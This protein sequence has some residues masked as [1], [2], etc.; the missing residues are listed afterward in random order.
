MSYE[1]PVDIGETSAMNLHKYIFYILQRKSIIFGKYWRKTKFSIS[2]K[3][4]WATSTIY[5]KAHFLTHIR[6]LI[7]SKFLHH[8]CLHKCLFQKWCNDNKPIKAK[9]NMW[10]LDITTNLQHKAPIVKDI[11]RRMIDEVQSLNKTLI[12]TTCLSFRWMMFEQG[13]WNI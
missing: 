3:L 11:K 8:Y 7:K 13:I 9:Q 4:H 5:S 2:T 12:L 10:C 1:V 6:I